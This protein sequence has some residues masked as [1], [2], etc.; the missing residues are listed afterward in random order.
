MLAVVINPVW[1]EHRTKVTDGERQNPQDLDLHWNCTRKWSSC[2]KRLHPPNSMLFVMILPRLT[3]WR[4]VKLQSWQYFLTID[5]GKGVKQTKKKNKNTHI[6]STF[7]PHL[8]VAWWRAPGPAARG[9]AAPWCPRSFPCSRRAAPTATAAAPG[10]PRRGKAWRAPSAP[11]RSIQQQQPRGSRESKSI[12]STRHKG[13][14]TSGSS[15]RP[16]ASEGGL[17][18]TDAKFCVFLRCKCP[19]LAATSNR[20]QRLSQDADL[21]VCRD[22]SSIIT[23]GQAGGAVGGEIHFIILSHCVAPG[24]SSAPLQRSRYRITRR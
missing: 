17:L 14:G 3:H 6:V 8:L 19:G 24:A 23:L 7:A 16:A 20:L 11:G 2:K 4:F 12:M 1:P 22:L 18:M 21:C 13:T 15:Q 5:I 9:R 10:T